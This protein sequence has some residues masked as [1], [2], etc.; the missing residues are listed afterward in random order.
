M[1][2]FIDNAAVESGDEDN[3]DRFDEE[4]ENAVGHDASDDFVVAD[5]DHTVELAQACAVVRRTDRS[6]EKDVDQAELEEETRQLALDHG[7]AIPEQRKRLKKRNRASQSSTSDALEAYLDSCIMEEAAAQQQMR[8]ERKQQRRKAKFM[9]RQE[10]AM[11]TRD[12]VPL[13][14]KSLATSKRPRNGQKEH[15]NPA[16]SSPAK[17][18][19]VSNEHSKVHSPEAAAVGNIP[20]QTGRAWTVDLFS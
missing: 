6:F 11:K 1:S 15:G 5:E 12:T 19:R 8:E 7:L 17:S 18:R 14:R 13:Q 4:L 9:R 16:R 3:I 2:A 20:R 10:V